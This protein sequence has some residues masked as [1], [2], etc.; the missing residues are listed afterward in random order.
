MHEYIE[1]RNTIGYYISN[2]D[3]ADLNNA[4]S[5]NKL[6]LK[7]SNPLRDIVIN[8]GNPAHDALLRLHKISHALIG[9]EQRVHSDT[10]KKET[11]GQARDRSQKA[12]AILG[13][14][15]AEAAEPIQKMLGR[16]VKLLKD[17][18]KVVRQKK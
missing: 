10:N 16:Y 17:S 7:A 6:E 8:S 5:A 18:N 12:H 4:L 11:E 3:L 13:K 1:G 14:F 9:R 15:F 2:K